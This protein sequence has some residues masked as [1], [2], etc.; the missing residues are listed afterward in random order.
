MVQLI[1]LIILIISLS[2]IFFIL[3]KKIT[4]LVNLPQNGHHGLKKPEFISKIEKKIKDTHFHFF[5]K[6]MFL[7]RI[8]SKFRIWILK[9]ERKVDVLLQGIRKKAQLLDKEL[10]KKK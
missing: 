9:I 8:L 6:Q 10:K 1:V 5:E 3:F 4:V 7:H 2:I